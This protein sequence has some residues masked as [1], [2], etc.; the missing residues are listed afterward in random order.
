MTVVIKILNKYSSKNI[1]NIIQIF[2]IF[3]S[4]LNNNRFSFD[5]IKNDAL[6]AY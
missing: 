1:R 5:F 3:L 2:L 6:K 4:F